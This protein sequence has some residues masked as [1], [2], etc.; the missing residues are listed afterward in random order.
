M[1]ISLP[2]FPEPQSKEPIPQIWY[3]DRASHKRINRIRELSI[4]FKNLMQ[5]TDT[6]VKSEILNVMQDI[7]S[8]MDPSDRVVIDLTGAHSA[9]RQHIY[10]LETSRPNP[11]FIGLTHFFNASDGEFVVT[12]AGEVMF[13]PT[14]V[15]DHAPVREIEGSVVKT[16]PVFSIN[17]NDRSSLAARHIVGI[18]YVIERG[19][20]PSALQATA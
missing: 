12:E 7:E 13:F 10:A 17:P 11:R 6:G 20:I 19:G 1:T 8:S 3:T 14:G 16:L 15:F 2:E 18:R 9:K 5:R 4:N